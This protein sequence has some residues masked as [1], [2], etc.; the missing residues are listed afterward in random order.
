MFCP[1]GCSQ[2]IWCEMFEIGIN[3][4]GE[5]IA[6][7]ISTGS[8]LKYLPSPEHTPPSLLLSMSRYNLRAIRVSVVGTAGSSLPVISSALP[9]CLIIFSISGRQTVWLWSLM[10]ES[11]N[12]AIRASMSAIISS[13]SGLSLYARLSDSIYSARRL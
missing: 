11:I 4:S 13:L 3:I 1:S 9:S 10:A 12:S 7:R 6:R 8:M 5:K 2:W